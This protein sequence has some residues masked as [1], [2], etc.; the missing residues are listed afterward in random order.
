MTVEKDQTNDEAA[1]RELLDSFAKAFRDKDVDGVMAPFAKNIVS[2]DILPPLQTVSAETFVT[3]WQQFFESHQGP[4]HVEFPD[5]RI[6]T[7]DDV[8]FSYC[9][10][11]IKGTLKSGQQ[12][13]W[14]LRWTA[15]YRKTNGRWLIVHEHVSV[16]VDLRSGK[17][18]MDLKP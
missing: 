5:I 6:A 13:D 18:L 7:G 9:V 16:P 17:A 11:R 15:C 14:W 2:F 12:T 1:I 10:H 4:I 3:H 8:A